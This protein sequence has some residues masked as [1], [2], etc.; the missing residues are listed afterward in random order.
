MVAH[1]L[2]YR[3]ALWRAK[4]QFTND[5]S[6]IEL[7]ERD[8]SEAETIAERS[9][10]QLYLTLHQIGWEGEAPAEPRN[11]V[12]EVGGSAGASPS[13]WLEMAGEKL[14][15]AKRLV[16][17]TEKPYEPHVPDWDDWEPPEYVGVFKNGEIVGYYCRNHEVE[18]AEAELR[19]L[20]KTNPK[21]QSE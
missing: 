2:L 14:D 5:K 19:K 9:R 11:P 20:Q 21:S 16:K 1:G 8:L 15:D 6:Q 12:S 18:A 13:R 10:T 7:A 4:Y 3:S 17:E